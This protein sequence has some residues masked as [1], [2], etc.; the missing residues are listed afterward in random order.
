MRG[1][2]DQ[3]ATIA[4]V[5]APAFLRIG[6]AERSH[7]ARNAIAHRQAVQMA[8][9]LRRVV[10]D[11]FWPPARHETGFGIQR[12][13]AREQRVDE[14]DRA[15]G[16][17]SHFVDVDMTGDMSAPRHIHGIMYRRIVQAFGHIRHVAEFGDLHHRAEDQALPIRGHAH[18]SVE[19][20]EMCVDGISVRPKYHQFAGLVSADDQATAKLA[21]QIRKVGRVDA[22]EY[23]L[24]G[25]LGLGIRGWRCRILCRGFSVGVGRPYWGGLCLVGGFAHAGII[26]QC[27]HRAKPLL[28]AD[29]WKPSRK[30][31]SLIEKNSIEL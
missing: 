3:N 5:C 1:H 28:S 21:Q 12:A 8:A 13:Q 20:A 14:P 22:A 24:D 6:F 16:I 30:I 10:A 19:G 27:R 9:I 11:K 2:V 29:H 25:L 17:P 4:L 23:L 7:V 18:R 26:A 15:V 31:V